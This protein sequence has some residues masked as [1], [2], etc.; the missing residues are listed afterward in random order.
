[1]IS[2]DFSI[3]FLVFICSWLR[4]WQGVET[5]FGSACCFLQSFSSIFQSCQVH[6]GCLSC[7]CFSREMQPSQVGS[8]ESASIG[9]FWHVSLVEANGKTCILGHQGPT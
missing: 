2:S 3:G 7:G 8:F 6:G 1:M 4:M 5:S 9:M